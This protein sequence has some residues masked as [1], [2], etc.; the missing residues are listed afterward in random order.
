MIPKPL[1]SIGHTSTWRG[2]VQGE[3]EAHCK[4][5]FG[6]GRGGFKW[7]LKE[8]SDVEPVS[9]IRHTSNDVK[10]AFLNLTH[11]NIE[12]LKGKLRLKSKFHQL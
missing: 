11:R 2:Y 3:T 5:E 7:G 9:V 1:S 4:E 8:I 10:A 6:K 12:W